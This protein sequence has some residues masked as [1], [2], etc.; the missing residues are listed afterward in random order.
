MKRLSFSELNSIKF[1]STSAQIIGRFNSLLRA[2]NHLRRLKLMRL[3]F[4]EDNNTSTE[5]MKR[6]IF[7]ISF[8]SSALFSVKRFGPQSKASY[9]SFS[10][11]VKLVR[12]QRV[13]GKKVIKGNASIRN[14]FCTNNGEHFRSLC[15]IY[16]QSKSGTTAEKSF[17]LETS[18]ENLENR[19]RCVSNFL[20]DYLFCVD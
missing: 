16:G 14:T 1:Y 17:A 11:S 2:H 5:R 7:T 20:F 10:S 4:T 18:Q 3:P 13:T 19:L 12:R 6:E 15:L 9:L 8:I